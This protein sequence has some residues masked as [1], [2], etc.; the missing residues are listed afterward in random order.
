MNRKVNILVAEKERIISLD[1]ET[2]LTEWGYAVPEVT[3]AGSAVLRAVRQKHPDLV[4]FGTD[5][6]E[7]MQKLVR[8][9]RSRFS[10]GIV[11]LV[12]RISEELKN[13]L[14]SL[15][16]VY[17]LPKP[18]NHEDLHRLVEKALLDQAN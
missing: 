5:S 16:S 17:F 2:T 18:F 12:D 10:G 6:T 8:E 13:L 11:L 15:R 4:I 7:S 14:V 1:L 3:C 9:I